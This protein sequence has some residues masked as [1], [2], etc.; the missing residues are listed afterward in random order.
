MTKR[1]VTSHLDGFDESEFEEQFNATVTHVDE[2][3]GEVVF[4]TAEAQE[5]LRLER[6]DEIT[7]MRDM[8]RTQRLA[9]LA[10]QVRV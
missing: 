2:N 6:R 7:V 3:T 10:A 8:L 9:A 4:A 5:Q 1:R